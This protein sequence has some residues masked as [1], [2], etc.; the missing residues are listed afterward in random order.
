ML[1]HLKEELSSLHDKISSHTLKAL[2]PG[3]QAALLAAEVRPH[4]ELPITN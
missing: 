2:V 4:T 1:T 3:N